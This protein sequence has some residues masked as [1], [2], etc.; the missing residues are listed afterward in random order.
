MRKITAIEKYKGSTYSVEFEDSEEKE[1]L[2]GEIIAFYHLKAGMGVPESAWEEISRAGKVRTARERALYLLDYR[3]YSYTELF[4][5]LEKNYPDDVCFEVMGRLVEL[6]MIDDRR[7][8]ENLARHLCEG[9]HFGCYRSA[10]EM[11]LKGI[12]GELIE[13]A[14]QPYKENA[15][16]RIEELIGE[17]YAAKIT[18]RKSLDRVKNA[19]VRLG[20]S[21]SQVNEA[22]GAFDIELEDE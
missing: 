2:N 21:Y 10:R 5:K 4:R 13:E 7:Y 17:K 9:K 18:D 14:L 20:Y 19:L 16:E 22:L 12:D 15:V 3:D 6:G 1:Y 11:R 8:A